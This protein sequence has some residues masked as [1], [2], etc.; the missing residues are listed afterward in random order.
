MFTAI[1]VFSA[2]KK[3]KH[4]FYYD[5][6]SLFIRHRIAEFEKAI[7]LTK[8][9][10][11]SFND[12]FWK[13]MHEISELINKK[14]VV[15]WKDYLNKSIGFRITPK[16]FEKIKSN[17]LTNRDDEKYIALKR[18]NV[19]IDADIVVHIISVLWLMNVGRHLDK[20]VDKD[21]YAYKLE[22]TG[23]DEDENVVKGLRLYKPYFTQYQN[24]RDNAI[25]KAEQLFEEKKDV[26][27]LS[28]DIKDYFHSV[29]IN[30]RALE[31]ELYT[32]KPFLKNIPK[33]EK[34][35][36]LLLS[37]NKIYTNKIKAVKSLP[38]LAIN[39]TILPIGLLSSGL[40]GNLY[41]KEFD[42]QVKD[43][44]NPSYYGRYVDDILFVM[45]N[46]TV[47]QS[48]ISP[49]NFFLD[50]YFVKR[51]LLEFKVGDNVSKE[52]IK[53]NRRNINGEIITELSYFEQP[54]K[55][56]TETEYL[57]KQIYSQQLKF[58]IAVKPSLEIQSQKVILQD[59]DSKQSPAIIN[60]FKK[61]LEKNRS[62]FRFLPDED[63]VDKEFD[64]EAFSLHY[65]DSL[66]KLRSIKELSE[67]KYGA[68]KY[69]AGKIFSTSLSAEKPDKKTAVQ[70]LTFFKGLVGLSF[71]TLWEK[72]ATY[73]IINEQTDS[74]VKFYKKSVSSINNI[75]YSKYTENEF[76]EVVKKKMQE[77]LVFYLKI[78]LATP[79][80]YNPQLLKKADFKKDYDE[81]LQMSYSIREANMFRHA[82]IGL[83]GINLT[84]YLFV[85]NSNTN[86]LKIGNDNLKF[87]GTLNLSGEN[88]EISSHAKED[89]LE[90]NSRLEL[91]APK[92]VHLH[93]IN[94]LQIFK[95]VHSISHVNQES[96]EKINSIPDK[97]FDIYWH[98]NQEW[99][100]YDKP[101][102]IDFSIAIEQAKS[103]YFKINK[104]GDGEKIIENEISILGSK[105]SG[106]NKRIA[107]ANIKVD[108]NNIKS[109][110]LGNPN[111]SKER[112]QELFDLINLVETSK[113]DLLVLPEVSVPYEWIGLL[114]YQSCRR[115]VG[116]IAGLEHWVNKFKFAFN[117]MVTILPIKKDHYTTCLINV[118][119]KNHYS[120]EEKKQLKGYRLLIP[121][122]TFPRIKKTYNLFH[123][124][125]CYFSVYNCF[126]LAD[127]SDRAL[128]KS[129][130][131]FIVA[132]EYNKDINYF[133][134]IAGSWVR[135]IHCF[136]IQ[137]NSSDYGDS[138]IIRPSP[139][140]TRD[141]L[142]IKGGEKALIMVGTLTIKELRDFQFKEYEL[143]KEDGFFKPTPPDFGK[144]NVEKRILDIDIL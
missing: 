32:E 43:V 72:V 112:R 67:D 69:L 4:Y 63:E 36:T 61:N 105:S 116:I 126:E 144:D 35:F 45:T 66:N 77:D 50:K 47:N 101:G 70:I 111:T 13:K 44:L 123:W 59:L 117:F 6:T 143:Q 18:I 8:G 85:N 122:E 125:K 92:Y 20:W 3:F 68:S 115:N 94:L 102:F 48:A 88:T 113:S 15:F 17:I 75:V 114:V 10:D 118:R 99:K 58:K 39:E 22:L 64:E 89:I 134:E 49:V 82:W 55:D 139:S 121:S 54:V 81:L 11:E 131:D 98:I 26:V 133:S 79:M 71:H 31:Q 108:A 132:S 53:K 141:I 73:F 136:F 86:L 120:H 16:A 12:A 107:V 95:V 130:V 42:L 1:E 2:Y 106:I 100:Y 80:A 9:N 30:L 138:R 21:N 109:S 76:V 119:L 19:F 24:W 37:I 65:N 128:F 14:G 96:V 25:K 140:V 78:A 56:L 23:E 60:N 41:L 129:K 5:N 97:A 57:I 84:N 83:P 7:E 103:E 40:L 135:D 104:A 29:K 74:L 27:I 51:K 34:L 62:E 91:L 33:I 124:K 38:N 137:V 110:Y 52:F 142:Q 46:T 87:N 90:I 28:L 93:E 127:I